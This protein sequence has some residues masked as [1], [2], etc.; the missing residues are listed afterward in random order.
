[1]RLQQL[2]PNIWRAQQGT[3]LIFN[4]WKFVGGIRCRYTTLSFFSLFFSLSQY[5]QFTISWQKQN[6][7]KFFRFA[8]CISFLFSQNS[9][10]FSNFVEMFGSFL[11]WNQSLITRTHWSSNIN[12]NNW[13]TALNYIENSV[14]DD[15]GCNSIN[16]NEHK[17][18][19]SIIVESI[20]IFE[21]GH[22]R[23]IH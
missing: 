1:M 5:S 21:I 4:C 10:L 7:K 17:S 2:E 19:M 22:E 6:A 20:Y 14:N 15:V 16:L 11:I 13:V 9:R 18:R 23:K 8:R 12:N 3:N